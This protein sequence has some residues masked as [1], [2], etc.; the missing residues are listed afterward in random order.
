MRPNP[1]AINELPTLRIST[2]ESSSTIPPGIRATLAPGAVLEVRTQ[3]QPTGQDGVLV[4]GT[5]IPAT[6]PDNIGDSEP[7]T[8]Q[9]VRHDGTILLRMLSLSPEPLK[10]RPTSLVDDALRAL[11]GE[12]DVTVLREGLRPLGRE[13]GTSLRDLLRPLGGGTP[14]SAAADAATAVLRS[15]LER[16]AT[17]DAEAFNTPQTVATILERALNRTPSDAVARSIE[18]GVA[19]ARQM[20]E[21]LGQGAAAAREI[22]GALKFIQTLDAQLQA[23]L[24]TPGKLSF[25]AT[26]TSDPAVYEGNVAL[27]IAASHYAIASGRTHIL[28]R[29]SHRLTTTSPRDNPL[30][31]L[32]QALGGLSI[33]SHE[34]ES[35]LVAGFSRIATQLVRDLDRLRG[36][37]IQDDSIRTTLQGAKQQID[38]L[39]T[40]ERPQ[41]TR[42]EAIVRTAGAIDDL[43][44]TTEAQEILRF[45]GPQA[46][47]LG[48]PAAAIIPAV[49]GGLLT[50]FE[51]SFLPTRPPIEAD[52]ESPQ[53]RA[54][55]PFQRIRCSFTLPNLGPVNADIAHRPGEI[56]LKL[57]TETEAAT[58]FLA[59]RQQALE[60]ALTTLGFERRAVTTR[61]GVVSS[62]LPSWSRSIT[63]SD[64]IA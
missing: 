62:A 16:G 63:R 56:L 19:S 53:D 37:P 4:N 57:V 28:D 51:F 59:A 5:F 13:V 54:G 1:A 18:G 44:R 8:V 33:E 64:V 24:A 12:S 30:V 35:N 14:A 43:S 39:L 42:A 48:E 11:L 50:R 29:I 34:G 45:L 31:V 2:T 25:D 36:T 46:L 23:L 9:V 49:I 40:R 27:F 26:T 55:T 15:L 38:Q 60:T 58:E 3:R 61:T 17:L 21:T 41:T 52:D 47:A 7:L 32:L 10:S 20:L 6:L 22:P